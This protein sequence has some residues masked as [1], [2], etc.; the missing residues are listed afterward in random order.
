MKSDLQG[1]NS[2]QEMHTSALHLNFL[3][4]LH[5]YSVKLT[6]SNKK[7]YQLSVCIVINQIYSFEVTT[8]TLQRFYPLHTITTTLFLLGE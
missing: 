3:H 1:Y 7:K 4:H 8:V 5:S 2:K 6:K